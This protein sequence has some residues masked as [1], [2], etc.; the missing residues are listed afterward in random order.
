MQHILRIC[1]NNLNNIMTVKT[2]LKHCLLNFPRI[3]PNALS[4]Y[5]HWFCVI[6]NGYEWKD[7]ELI[8]PYK[9]DKKYSAKTI[10]QAVLN[11][12]ENSM[13]N[14]WKRTNEA[15]VSFFSIYK[16]EDV[17]K[18]LDFINRY[19]LSNST[20]NFNY[21]KMI[22]D[23]DKRMLDFSIPVDPVL[24]KKKDYKFTFYP[25][26]EYSRICN[27]PDDIKDDWLKAAKQMIDIMEEHKDLVKDEDNLFDKA[28]ERVNNLYNERFK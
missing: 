24:S 28:K 19:M 1:G 2:Q 5:D 18:C 23:T 13:V 7:G 8:V 21:I 20:Q 22:F 26:Y 6:G 15:P 10:K 16:D 17:E 3:F 27:I 4:V 9:Q 11:F 25:L 12:I 14:I